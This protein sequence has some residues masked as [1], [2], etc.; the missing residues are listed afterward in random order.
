M[1]EDDR[2]GC[3]LMLSMSGW[4][5]VYAGNVSLRITFWYFLAGAAILINVLNH[6]L[7]TMLPQPDY[8]DPAV[9]N[10]NPQVILFF[11]FMALRTLHHIFASIAVWRSSAKYPG[12]KVWSY[13]ARFLM[14]IWNLVFAGVLLL[15]LN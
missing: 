2:E 10:L 5:K 11:T 7:A 9:T 1:F 13:I 6:A 4:K 12:K 15:V 14:I 8:L 3:R